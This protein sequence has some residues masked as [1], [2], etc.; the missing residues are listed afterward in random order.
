MDTATARF[1]VRVV[2]VARFGVRVT[3]R[4]SSMENG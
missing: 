4:V 3:L 1:T 2:F